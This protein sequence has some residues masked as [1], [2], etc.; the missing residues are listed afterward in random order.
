MSDPNIMIGLNDIIKK[1]DNLT[2]FDQYSG[3]VVLFLLMTIIVIL[4]VSYFHTIINVQPVINDWANQRCKPTIIPFA[5]LINPPEGVSASEYTSEN[6]NYC[7]QNI[8]SGVTSTALEPLSFV[9]NALTSLTGGIMEDINSSR[10]MINKVR[11]SI[12]NI[13]EEIMGRLMNVMVPLMKIVI[14]FKN[15]V[16]KAQGVTM[17]GLFTLL[18]SY[19]GFKSLLGSIAQ[20]IVDILVTMVIM[21]AAFWAV[22]LTWGMAAAQSVVFT[23]IVIPMAIIL[24]FM[25]KTLH[26]KHNYKLPKLKCFDK[27]TLLKMSDATYKQIIDIEVGE[28]LF[29]NNIVTSKMKVERE[30]S[31]MYNLENVIVS[32]SHIVK[33][34]NTWIPV[35]N[36]P[37]SIK[38][39]PY[40]EPYLY[41]LN[42]TDK[43]IEINQLI[44]TDWDELYD[45]TLE[46]IVKN[47]SVLDHNIN[48]IHKYLD[49]GFS[50]NTKINLKNG[51]TAFINQLNIHDVLENGETVYGIVEI[52]GM[53]LFN[54]FHYCLGE[55]NNGTDGYA[56]NFFNCKKHKL[57][58]QHD[59]LYNLLTD[60][61]T[62]MI[63]DIIIKDYNEAIDRFF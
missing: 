52:D 57:T 6:F 21:I 34:N 12:Q 8:L 41:C 47:I 55:N 44:F 23:A 36:H 50:S 24:A 5:G 32:D 48:H 2:Y 25:S 33:Y 18:G 58:K 49:Y 53:T 45:D 15:L 60:K 42:T 11:N 40:N 17:S 46:R 9:T 59:K 37:N 31:V 1:Y 19:Y 20:F 26:L 14:N 16:S 56:P 13:T 10:G 22:P 7:T 28:V 35:S 43:I 54:Q 39:E 61:G 63:N 51:K 30:G 38:H 29:N 3:S 4:L 27:N 62:F